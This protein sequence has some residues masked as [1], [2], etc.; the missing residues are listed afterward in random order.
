LCD[1]RRIN[2]HEEDDFLGFGHY[3][4]LTKTHLTKQPRRAQGIRRGAAIGG[5]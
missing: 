2:I 3:Y 5:D 4:Q 1:I